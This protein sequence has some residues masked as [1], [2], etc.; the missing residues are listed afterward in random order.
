METKQPTCLAGGLFSLL[1]M[2]QK[3]SPVPFCNEFL[4]L[5]YKKVITK[6][7]DEGV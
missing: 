4:T 5:C 3:P 1:N 6:F 7:K 2:R